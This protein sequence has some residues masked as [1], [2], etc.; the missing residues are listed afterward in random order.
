MIR[1][2]IRVCGHRLRREE[3]GSTIIEVLASAIVLVLISVGVLGGLDGATNQSNQNR[4]RSVAASVAQ[5]DQERLRGLRA[6]QLFDRNETRTV[7]IRGAQFSVNSTAAWLLDS[8]GTDFPC[9]AKGNYMRIRSSVSWP[10]MGTQPITVTSLV[11]PSGQAGT[12]SATITSR[13]L[14]GLPGIG[15]TMTGPETKTVTTD[16]RGCV[17]FGQL[18]PGEYLLTFSKPGYIDPTGVNPVSK[19]ITVNAESTVSETFRY[20]Q[21]GSI[22]ASFNTKR[23]SAGQVVSF[24]G[25]GT[26]GTAFTSLSH[27]GL[28]QG[29]K[30][31][32]V[33]PVATS[34]TMTNL[35]PFTDAYSVYAGGCPGANPAS[36]TTSPTTSPFAVPNNQIVM[37]GS[38]HSVA[39]RVPSVR[40]RYWTQEN[41]ASQER[42][43]AVPAKNTTSSSATGLTVVKLTATSPGCGG[44]TS[45]SM[46]DCSGTP[47]PVSPACTPSN[48]TTDTGGWIDRPQGRALL[49]DWGVPVGTYDICV[50]LANS[51]DPVGTLGSGNYR[52]MATNV[53][54]K[55]PAGETVSF[56][57]LTS[58]DC[59]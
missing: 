29:T 33:N 53:M 23:G 44:V 24:P 1:T 6:R 7:A 48:V 59:P 52:A 22:T 12:V 50:D 16:A 45:W 28:L 42:W 57:Q 20:D 51:Y 49:E 47:Q 21:P 30:S 5:A 35:F 55:D 13:N 15:V 8:G 41:N 18:Q 31:Y 3:A 10:G 2:S 11:T 58:G 9:S 4:L 39:V 27:S 34:A 14:V 26:P 19:E 40:L 32:A 43:V 37:P 56:N 17:F 25:W 54:V 36:Y 38:A 46:D